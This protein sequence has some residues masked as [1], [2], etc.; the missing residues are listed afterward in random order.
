[1]REAVGSGRLDRRS[2]RKHRLLLPA[3]R[4]NLGRPQLVLVRE[5]DGIRERA[6]DVDT[7]DRHVTKLQP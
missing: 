2:R 5:Q 3:R 7:E 4:R 1:M 6:A